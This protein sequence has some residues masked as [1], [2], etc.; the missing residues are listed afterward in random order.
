M[1]KALKFVQG[2]VAKKDF[3]PAMTHFVIEDGMVRSFNGTMALSSPIDIDMRCAP[4]AGPMVYAIGQCAEVVSLG[5]TGA[6]RL[7]IQSGPFKAFIDCIEMED[8]PHRKP[9]GEQIAF[10]GEA[11]LK[12]IQ[13]LTPFIGDDASRPWTNGILLRGQSAFATNNV[14]LVEHWLG[15]NIPQT[16]NIPMPAVKELARVGM[17][18]TH[19]QMTEDSISF[20]YTD[21]SWLRTQLYSTEWPD[22]AKVL[23]RPSNAQPIPEGL[24]EGLLYIKPFVEKPEHVYFIDGHLCTHEE[25]EL[26]A[27]YKVEGLHNEGMFRRGML[28]K[29]EGV[30]TSVDFAA[31]PDPLMFFGDKV[32][33]AILGLRK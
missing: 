14:C 22:I 8:V 33:G 17:P 31:Y 5:L 29:L 32:R 13:V 26:G 30:A 9:E 23:D 6:N 24:F 16:I 27:S 21:G 25:P 15:V 2:A 7:R 4:K 12:A 18:P 11:L 19:A 3:V 1:L 28:A 20:H 10:D